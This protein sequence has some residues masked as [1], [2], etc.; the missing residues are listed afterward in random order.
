MGP[1]GNRRTP[2]RA[3]VTFGAAELH[4]DPTR[5]RAW[6]LFVDGVAQSH[7]DLDDPGYLALDYARRLGHVLGRWRPS[8]V[9]GTVL[10]LGAG[11]L[12]LAR[13]L[14]HRRPALAQKVVDRDP[15]LLAFVAERLPFPGEIVTEVGD[16]REV[17]E[18]EPGYA[19]DLIIADVFA[20]AAMPA[21]VAAA[22]FARAAR[23]ALKR[24]GLLAMNITDVPPLSW[25][26]IQAATVAAAGVPVTLYGDAA[27]LRGRRAGNVI[28]LAGDVPVIN[29]G[30]HE[31][32]LRGADLAKFVGGARPRPDEPR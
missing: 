14:H 9:P 24:D 7:V 15:L 4:P 32:I 11:A 23:R 3:A 20:G 31:T 13:Y 19:Y 12:T 2:V 10:H 26:R 16:A 29:T 22:G 30:R 17:L 27:T 8:G 5:P 1:P 28:L 18:H 6:T 21:S 25:T